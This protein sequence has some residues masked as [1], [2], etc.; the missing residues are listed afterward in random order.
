MRK[1]RPTPVNHLL[2]NDH[3]S[4]KRDTPALYRIKQHSLNLIKINKIIF[5]QLDIPL[6]NVYQ[7]ANY[8]QG[9]LVIEISSAN[10][11][12][13]M[14]AQQAKLTQTLRRQLLRDLIAIEIKIAPRLAINLARQTTAATDNLPKRTLSLTAASN[15]QQLAYHCRSDTLRAALK[16]LAAHGSGCQKTDSNDDN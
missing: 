3:I 12:L 2:D 13:P 11:L 15:L 7:V 9:L 5:N 14:R 8:R 4:K 10:W 1:Q 16:K 6:R